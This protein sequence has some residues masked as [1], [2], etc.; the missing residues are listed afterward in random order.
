MIKEN[1]FDSE[2]MNVPANNISSWCTSST[3]TICTRRADTEQNSL[4]YTEQELEDQ[5]FPKQKGRI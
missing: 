5:Q 3:G 4:W 2:Y 1:V